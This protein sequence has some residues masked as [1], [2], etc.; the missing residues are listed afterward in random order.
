M[1]SLVK[2]PESS[3]TIESF[4]KGG[5]FRRHGGRGDPLLQLQHAAMVNPFKKGKEEAAKE[6]SFPEQKTAV[7]VNENRLPLL[8]HED[9]SCV[10]QVQVDHASRMDVSKDALQA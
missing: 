9:V 8:R 3:Q 1:I 2:D 4:E 7:K 6:S 10:S 5:L